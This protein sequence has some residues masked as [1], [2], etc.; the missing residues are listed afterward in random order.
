MMQ[1]DWRDVLGALS[2]QLPEDSGD[3][4]PETVVADSSTDKKQ[5]GFVNIALERKGRA[6]K[7][8]TI[9]YGFTVA[10]SEIERIAAELKRSL[11]CGG[12]VRG[13][14]ILLQGDRQAQVKPILKK[15][16]FKTK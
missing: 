14:E 1:Q 13:G 11:G 5:T 6:G 9:L 4:F 10:D 12:S 8:A 3:S 2:S 16:G 7:T 15:M